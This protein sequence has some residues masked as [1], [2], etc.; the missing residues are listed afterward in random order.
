ML[1]IV[2]PQKILNNPFDMNHV[3]LSNLK[4]H[5]AYEVSKFYFIDNYYPPACTLKHFSIFWSTLNGL[6]FNFDQSTTKNLE[7]KILKVF[8]KKLKN[9]SSTINRKKCL[10]LHFHLFKQGP[11]LQRTLCLY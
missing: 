8:D 7:K 11:S 3:A 9:D 2:Q 10:C 6:V 4:L 5:R 1:Y